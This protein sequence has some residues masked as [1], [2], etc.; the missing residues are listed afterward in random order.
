VLYVAVLNAVAVHGLSRFGAKLRSVI[1][2]SQCSDTK[3]RIAAG[4]T[5]ISYP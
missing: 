4:R 1:A 2:D 3:I 5:V